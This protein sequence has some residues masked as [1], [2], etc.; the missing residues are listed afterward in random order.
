MY[1]ENYTSPND[2]NGEEFT[3]CYNSV[4]HSQD[5]GMSQE[6]CEAFGWYANYYSDKI[7]Q[8]FDLTNDGDAS[9]DYEADIRAW[10]QPAWDHFGITAE[11]IGTLQ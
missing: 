3:G 8:I 5:E 2:P 6:E 4:T 9:A 7:V 1:L 11:D 10:L